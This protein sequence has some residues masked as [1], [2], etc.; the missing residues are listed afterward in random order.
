M[1]KANKSVTTPATPAPVPAKT[2]KSAPAPKPAPV[3]T[4]EKPPAKKKAPV[5]KKVAAKPAETAPVVPTPP[6]TPAPAPVAKAP[7]KQVVVT[8]ITAQIDVGFGNALYLRGEGPGLS[9]EKGVLLDCIADDRWSYTFSDAERPIVFKF[10]LNDITWS[11]GED[12]VAA[13]GSQS[14]VTPAF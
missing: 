14:V 5:K 13:P 11:T 9:W 3:P 2:K 4:A 10:L 12:F 1:K 8:T 7:A 6:A